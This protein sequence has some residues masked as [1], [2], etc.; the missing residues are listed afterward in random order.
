MPYEKLKNIYPILQRHKWLTPIMAVRR[1]IKMINDGRMNRTVRELQS[2]KSDGGDG[3]Q[4]GALLEDLGLSE[5][6]S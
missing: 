3:A 4:I 2:L 5:S 1:W 6:K